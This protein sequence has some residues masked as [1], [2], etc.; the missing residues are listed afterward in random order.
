[1]HLPL[2]FLPILLILRADQAYSQVTTN[3]PLLG[4]VFPAPTAPA[5][6]TAVRKAQSSFPSYLNSLLRTG[7]TEYGTL[8]TQT[9]SFS[10]NIF[11]AHED[12]SL[13]SYHYA[14]PGLNG[15]LTSGKLD[16]DT[17][18]RIGSLSKLLTVYTLLVE[19][20]NENLD[21]PV[22]K[23][24]PELAAAAAEDGKN[25]LHN[26]KWEDIT[27]RALGS[28][29]SGIPRDCELPMLGI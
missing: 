25:E 18:Y 3:C 1:M 10:I 17:M 6:S 24:V 14:A 22:T 27:I 19:V 2:Q 4:P 20:G 16:D 13:F 29:L 8:D 7:V 21:D 15:S 28:H 5:A 11:S 9:T 23:Y 12:T 26:I